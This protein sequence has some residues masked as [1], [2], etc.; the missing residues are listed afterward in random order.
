[1]SNGGEIRSGAEEQSGAFAR[2][3]DT[4]PSL[5]SQW[6]DGSKTPTSAKSIN[7]LVSRFGGE[8][9]DILGIN[10]A[11]AVELAVDDLTAALIDMI[12]LLTPSKR[13]ELLQNLHEMTEV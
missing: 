4:K 3:V 8:V 10:P 9:Y 5:M 2:W 13:R 7:A 12:R 1:M 11:E 6:M